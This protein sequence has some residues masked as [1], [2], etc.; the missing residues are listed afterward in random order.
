[1]S[2]F[3]NLFSQE[4]W[5]V[6]VPLGSLYYGMSEEEF[7]MVLPGVLPEGT[8]AHGSLFE[9]ADL[10]GIQG[11]YT[12]NFFEN[13]LVS[14]HFTAEADAAY[15]V[16]D[17][18]TLENVE[19]NFRRFDQVA[20]EAQG[21][22]RAKLGQPSVLVKDTV[23]ILYTDWNAGAKA[24][25]DYLKAEWKALDESVAVVRFS[26]F[27]RA[28]NYEER[29]AQAGRDFLSQTYRLT[30]NIFGHEKS[31]VEVNGLS[32]GMSAEEAYL[33]RPEL[34]PR[35][36]LTFGTVE[37]KE[38]SSEGQ[39][40][41]IFEWFDGRLRTVKSEKK[42]T[43]VTHTLADLPALQESLDELSQEVQHFEE[44]MEQSHGK[45]VRTFQRN[46]LVLA[47]GIPLD[48][49]DDSEDLQLLLQWR[50]G[51]QTRV[52]VYLYA[53]GR[54]WEQN[55]RVEYFAHAGLKLG[56]A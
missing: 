8:L 42:F 22:I 20:Q 14:L 25:E 37:W 50:I 21:W 23:D 6:P 12:C 56:K 5:T 30:L 15:D 51:G 1:M 45:A 4:E 43:L 29:I 55:G 33:R 28:P 40:N 44:Q 2:F 48:G 19:L 13:K 34:F 35:G 16:N 7:R 46:E 10:F 53:W 18:L 3:R 52:S 49:E 41:W 36:L 32:P 38:L 27:G 26:M 54:T 47:D 39:R 9:E 11:T 24:G 17:P 31:K